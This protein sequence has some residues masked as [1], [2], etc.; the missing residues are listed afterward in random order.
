MRRDVAKLFAEAKNTVKLEQIVVF[1]N[2]EGGN[3]LWS[4]A[5]VG[6]RLGG[7]IFPAWLTP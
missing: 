4:K 1:H 2:T 7:Q 6:G 5:G 3:R